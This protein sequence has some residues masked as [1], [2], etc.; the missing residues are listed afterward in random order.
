MLKAIFIIA[1]LVAVFYLLYLNGYMII[2]AKRATLFFGKNRG[3]GARFVSCS[4]FMKKIVRFP[5]SGVYQ[6]DFGTELE[7]GEVSLELWDGKQEKVLFFVNQGNQMLTVE[8]KERY[9]LVLKFE[10]ATGSYHI[11]WE[12]IN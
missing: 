8:G 7:K 10:S 2:N 1:A 3:K 4:G 6:F 5:K 9:Y 11:D 12:L